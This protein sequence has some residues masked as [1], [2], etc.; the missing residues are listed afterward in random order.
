ME[1]QHGVFEAGAD[2]RREEKQGENGCGHVERGVVQSLRGARGCEGVVRGGGVSVGG[3]GAGGVGGAVGMAEGE[4]GVRPVLV[5]GDD[6]T[7][8]PP[9]ELCVELPPCG[10]GAGHQVLDAGF[11]PLGEVPEGLAGVV[12]VAGA[13]GG[14]VAERALGGA[15]LEDGPGGGDAAGVRGGGGCAGVAGRRRVPAP[16]GRAGSGEAASGE[17]AGGRL[18]GVGGGFRG[19]GA[20]VLRPFQRGV[21]CATV[22]EGRRRGAGPVAVSAGNG[23]VLAGEREVAE[24]WGKRV[25]QSHG[26]TEAQ[27]GGR[28]VA[29]K[30]KRGSKE[31]ENPREGRRREGERKHKRA[32]REWKGKR[33]GPAGN[34]QTEKVSR[35]VRKGREGKRKGK[36][37]GVG[38]FALDGRE[39][40]GQN[41]GRREKMATA[42]AEKDL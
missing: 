41:W 32:K 34:G 9:R 6:G 38:G 21:E 16:G 35:K 3:K 5:R 42:R 15:R 40:S 19:A 25:T 28:G 10:G 11:Q 33:N 39:G 22:P 30:R 26:E 36:V 37:G 31:K 14:A 23:A 29:T 1:R 12:A 27:R 20:A 17:A 18:G 13:L 2:G 24:G 8:V 4:A 7:C